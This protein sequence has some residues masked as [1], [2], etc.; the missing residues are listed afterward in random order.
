VALHESTL[1]FRRNDDNAVI[2]GAGPV[3]CDRGETALKQSNLLQNLRFAEAFRPDL[4][5]ICGCEQFM[6]HAIAFAQLTLT[7]DFPCI[8]LNALFMS[9]PGFTSF[10]TSC[11]EPDGCSSSPGAGA[12]RL[13][14]VW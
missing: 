10:L 5:D 9:F 7:P 1:S 14:V 4:P 13:F 6:K 3:Q 11:R 2:N 12:R 8:V